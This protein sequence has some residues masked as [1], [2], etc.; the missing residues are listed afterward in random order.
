MMYL[1]SYLRTWNIFETFETFGLLCAVPAEMP[2][3]HFL[4]LSSWKYHCHGSYDDLILDCLDTYPAK[5]GASMNG[6][7]LFMP[8]MM[9]DKHA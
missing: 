6:Y 7:Y 8:T 3:P 4:L 5:H 1:V 2:L 9:L